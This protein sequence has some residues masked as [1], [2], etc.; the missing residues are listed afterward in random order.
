MTSRARTR[1]TNTTSDVSKWKSLCNM[2]SLLE[3]LLDKDE[4][5][6]RIHDNDVE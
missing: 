1:A 3:A 4:D 5:T 2:T 6:D